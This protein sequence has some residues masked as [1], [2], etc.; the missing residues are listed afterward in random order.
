[1]KWVEGKR[2][3][4]KNKLVRQERGGKGSVKGARGG[5]KV[6]RISK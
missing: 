3:S 5:G 1:M 2:K 6:R 4:K